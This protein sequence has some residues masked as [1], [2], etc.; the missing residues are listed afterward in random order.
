[1]A[2]VYKITHI[3]TGLIYIGFTRYTAEVRWAGHIKLAECG[4]FK[5]SNISLA[6]RLSGKNQFRVD[7]LEDD[8][9]EDEAKKREVFWIKHFKAQKPGVLNGNVGARKK[10]ELVKLARRETQLARKARKARETQIAQTVWKA[11]QAERAT[12]RAAPVPT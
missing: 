11:A 3:P 7:T 5:S 12:R 6:I 1:M 4:A 8:L 10:S 9:P 2:C